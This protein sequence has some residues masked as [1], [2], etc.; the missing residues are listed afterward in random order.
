[1]KQCCWLGGRKGIQPVKN[2]AVGC[3]RGY[4]SGATCRFHM[5]QLMPLPL[6]VS[7]FS[8]IQIGF[9]FLV[10]AHLGSPGQKAVTMGVCVCVMCWCDY[11][12]GARCRL[13]AYGTLHPKT[14]SSLASFKSR[15]VF[16]FWYRLTQVVQE[17]RLLNS[18]N[19]VVVCPVLVI[20]IWYVCVMYNVRL[21]LTTN[22]LK[23]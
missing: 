3:W 20:W 16:P 4:F 17:K 5:A 11:L 21:I 10:P 15:R 19:V 23:M 6:T 12:S 8:T 7:C 18:C 2:W 1:M 22:L 9:T 13:F 14:P